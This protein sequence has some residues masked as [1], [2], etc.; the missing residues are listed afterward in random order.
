MQRYSSVIQGIRAIQGLVPVSPRAPVPS[1]SLSLSLS[2]PLADSEPLVVELVPEEVLLSA[3]VPPTV[4]DPSCSV[5]DLVLFELAGFFRSN[6][7]VPVSSAS[8]GSEDA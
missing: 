8:L 2:L 4:L 7:G 6:A 5:S 1:A 3:P